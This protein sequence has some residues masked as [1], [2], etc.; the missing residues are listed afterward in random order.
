MKGIKKA[1][2]ITMTCIVLMSCLFVNVSANEN[3]MLKG[4]TIEV[5][6]ATGRFSMDI[7]ANTAVEADTSFPLEDG[8]S[9]TI[10]ASY[11]PFDAHVDFGLIAPDGLF[12]GVTVTNGSIDQAIRVNQRGYYTLAIENNSDFLFRAG[13]VR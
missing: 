3:V 9:V 4:E 6:R 8:E 2:C 13:Q 7:P 12:Y 1:A 10:K 5:T 11:S